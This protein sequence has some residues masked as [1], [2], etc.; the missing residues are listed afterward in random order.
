MLEEYVTV[1]VF[2]GVVVVFSLIALV[3]SKLIRPSK[4]EP[5]KRTVYECGEK[6]F[7]DAWHQFSV[8]YYMYAILFVIFDVEILFLYPWAIKTQNTEIFAAGLLFLFIV[9]AGLVYEWRKGALEW[10]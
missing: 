7:S 2:T 1:A 6:P 10:Q 5:E 9:F 3:F 4:S 8:Q